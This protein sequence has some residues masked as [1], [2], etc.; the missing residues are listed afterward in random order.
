MGRGAAAVGAAGAVRCRP[1]RTAARAPPAPAPPAAA[2]D[3]PESAAIRVERS[4]GP[5]ARL[6]VPAAAGAAAA[7]G[8]QPGGSAGRAPGEDAAP[9]GS[10]TGSAQSKQPA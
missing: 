1:L 10:G 9:P 6:G 2:G 5:A 7:E 3:E 4:P 8:E